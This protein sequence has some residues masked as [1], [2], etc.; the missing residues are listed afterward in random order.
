MEFFKFVRE[1]FSEDGQGSASRTMMGVHA[2]AG[3]GWV[4]YHVI[5][6]AGHPLPDAVTLTGITSFVVAPYAINKFHGA[7]TAFSGNGKP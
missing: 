5:H 2:A 6:A 4:S 3:I 1:I 7:V